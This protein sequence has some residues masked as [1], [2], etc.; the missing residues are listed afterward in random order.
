M[1]NSS[2]SMQLTSLLSLAILIA[3]VAPLCSGLLRVPTSIRRGSSAFGR[4]HLSAEGAEE[5]SL[6]QRLTADMKQAMKAKEKERLAAV[7]GI[8]AAIKQ[9]EVDDQKPATYVSQ[10]CAVIWHH[11]E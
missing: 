5:L 8:Q 9:K 3:T 2:L 6:K 10:S 1:L 11:F 7:R 4:L